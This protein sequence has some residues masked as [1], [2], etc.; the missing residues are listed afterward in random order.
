MVRVD[1]KVFMAT[2]GGI[3]TAGTSMRAGMIADQIIYAVKQFRSLYQAD[4][5]ELLS[6]L[7]QSDPALPERRGLVFPDA[8][9]LR[10][11]FLSDAYGILEEKTH[12]FIQL[13]T[14]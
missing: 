6:H 4:P 2:G 5:G 9:S 11:V 10:F 13:G 8:P 3:S 14:L 12:S 7:Y 1:G